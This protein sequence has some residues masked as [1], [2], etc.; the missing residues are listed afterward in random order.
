MEE[1]T[2]GAD[3][4]ALLAQRSW[5][6]RVARALVRDGARSDDLEQAVW[7]R[8]L[9]RPRE[10]RSPR[11]WLG[12][13]LRNAASDLFRGEGRRRRREEAAA[14]P[15]AAPA[16]DEAV[17]RA[18]ALRRAVDA[19]LALREPY[20][21]VV[22]LRYFE[23]LPPPAIARR[24]GVP[25]E[26]V[27][28]RLRR[29]LEMLRERL[30]DA[31]GGDRRA[32]LALL[33]PLAGR[34][35]F[36]GLPAAPAAPAE[37]GAWSG[38]DAA[39]RAADAAFREGLAMTAKAAFAAGIGTAFAVGAAWWLIAGMTEPPSRPALPPAAAAGVAARPAPDP[40]GGS[41]TPPDSLGPTIRYFDSS[42]RPI[43][44]FTT[45]SDRSPVRGPSPL[46]R[47]PEP[48]AVAPAVPTAAEWERAAFGD[49]RARIGDASEWFADAVALRRGERFVAAP[50]GAPCIE[51]RLVDE[52][53]N[54]VGNGVVRILR[55]PDEGGRPVTVS[56]FAVGARGEFRSPELP[57]A[58]RYE[59][60]ASRVR[61]RLDA[62]ASG[63][64]ADGRKVT[65]VLARGGRME[66]RVVEQDGSPVRGR[67]VVAA[68]ALPGAAA[69]EGPALGTR[70]T[71]VVRTDGSFV[72]EGLGEHAFD[73]RVVGEDYLQEAPAGPHRPDDRVEIR[74]ARGAA[75][76]GRVVDLL[77]GDSRRFLLFAIPAAGTQRMATIG[78]DGAFEFRALPAGAVRIEVAPVDEPGRRISLASSAAPSV[79]VEIRLADAV[80]EPAGPR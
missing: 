32:W 8:A 41:P 47:P 11:A 23:D 72:L 57:A 9:E 54:P 53:G 61:G 35:P 10:V 29:A 19:A 67:V 66:G 34:G 22:V 12:T 2:P 78:P 76:T 6:R 71:A 16:A 60:R 14:R 70:S 49:A 27:R 64:S 68:E 56:L 7:L 4:A 13:A 15:E 44:Y 31:H 40:G 33:L 30:D 39:F 58:G 55:A 43:D 45:P 73:L 77:P 48:A 25:L 63:V 21:T 65:L 69:G 36:P 62:H 42:G 52:A 28:T 46:D 26:T 24:L 79:E 80:R 20:R 5:V 3:P 74:V 38:G 50:P 1:S 37:A 51:G 75:L 18:E 59:V 17:A